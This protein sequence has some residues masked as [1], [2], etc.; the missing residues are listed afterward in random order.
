MKR[1]LKLNMEHLSG[2]VDSIENY[3]TCIASLKNACTAFLEV[4]K[5]QDSV[6]YTTLSEEWEK[7]IIGNILQAPFINWY[8]KDAAAVSAVH[9]E[10]SVIMICGRWM[11]Q[12]ANEPEMKGRTGG[13]T[14]RP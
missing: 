2:T 5:K 9:F 10:Y 12:K 8:S 6:S 13:G 7:D 11:C 1:D 4:L 14:N 3:L